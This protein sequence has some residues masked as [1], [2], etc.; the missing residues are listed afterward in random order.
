MSYYQLEEC[1]KHSDIW[2]KEKNK[3]RMKVEEEMLD[4]YPDGNIPRENFEKKY[5]SLAF[6]KTDFF[7]CIIFFQL[8]RRKIKDFLSI[9]RYI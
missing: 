5:N 7:W 8:Y 6:I 3:I 1:L 2:I 4:D 9:Y